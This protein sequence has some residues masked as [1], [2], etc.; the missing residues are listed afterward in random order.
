MDAIQEFEQYCALHPDPWLQAIHAIQNQPLQPLPRLPLQ[1]TQYS[2]PP[3]PQEAQKEVEQ[4]KKQLLYQATV[5]EDTEST[6]EST[7]KHGSSIPDSKST[8]P[9]IPRLCATRSSGDSAAR[10]SNAA[11]LASFLA[12]FFGD[13]L[14]SF[15]GSASRFGYIECMEGMEVTG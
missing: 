5:E 9:T 14:T 2:T 12:S 7:T 6:T 10:L 4:V 15:F 3:T 13:L 8:L 1:S 11:F